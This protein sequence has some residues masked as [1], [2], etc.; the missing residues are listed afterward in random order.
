ME[1]EEAYQNSSSE[2]KDQAHD[3][4]DV[5]KEEGHAVENSSAKNPVITLGINSDTEAVPDRPVKK[6]RTAFFI[7]SDERRS[8][9]QKHHEG[10]GVATVG[11][12][13]GQM[14]ASLTEEEK[15]IYQQQAAAERERV[16]KDLEA[17]NK[18]HG[19]KP[20]VDKAL[21]SISSHDLSSL[22]YPS[23]RVRKICKLDSDVRGISKEALLLV[24]K[25]AELATVKL[26][27]ESV[28]VAQIQNRRKLLPEDVATVCRTRDQFS[29][30]KQDVIDLVREQDRQHE[31][32][33]NRSHKPSK[34]AKLP[35]SSNPITS[36]FGPK[37]K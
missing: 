8:E 21:T 33:D 32:N 27:K 36:Y 6:A 2:H 22:G 11:K 1:A 4:K 10:Q 9:V 24:T 16:T 35:I 14:W 17:W 34:I 18:R 5:T 20:S 25:A 7:F 3:E 13:L 15:Q 29:F 12:A 23:A 30:L 26:G 19:N 28:R 31:A 37:R